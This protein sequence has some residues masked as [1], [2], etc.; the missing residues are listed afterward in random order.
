[1]IKLKGFFSSLMK[2]D[3]EIFGIYKSKSFNGY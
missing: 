2:N 1:M 3:N